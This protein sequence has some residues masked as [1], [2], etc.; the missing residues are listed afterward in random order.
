MNHLL[1]SSYVFYLCAFWVGN[2]TLGLPIAR[3]EGTDS[4][5][6]RWLLVSSRTVRQRAIPRRL[7]RNL[8]QAL[9]QRGIYVLA[10]HEAKSIFAKKHSRQARQA[11]EA[12]LAYIEK[13]TQAALEH[14]A[15][16]HADR[17]RQ[18]AMK[19]MRR[20]K[21]ALESLNRQT[22][23]A[24]QVQN[25][26]LYLARAMLDQ[27]NRDAALKH[28][29]QC[30]SLVPDL[31][32]SLKDH[33]PHVMRLVDEA[34]LALATQAHGALKVSSTPSGCSV[35]INGRR[36]GASPYIATQ[37][38]QGHYRLQVACGGKHPSRVHPVHLGSKNQQVHIDARF[39][40]RLRTR[41]GIT[42]RYASS[43][44]ENRYRLCDA[45]RIA[46]TL[47]ATSVVL[48]TVLNKQHLR[49]DHIDVRSA[50][51][52]ASLWVPRRRL[53][54]HKHASTLATHLHTGRSIHWLGE[55]RTRTTP[56]HPPLSNKK[57]ARLHSPRKAP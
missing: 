39:E 23:V 30:R 24:Q 9:R 41:K 11:R 7:E 31:R 52:V 38:P 54:K 57:R 29:A 27:G 20:A 43:A 16:G 51:V 21:Q 6:A 48:I 42:L 37:L 4:T 47:Q 5:H 33:P 2:L 26:C 14:V 49:L 22:V 28:M 44:Q 12:D 10:G 8:A 46:K 36:V 32:P 3:A 35:M 25:S 17:T 19:V 13:H 50:G 18:A 53:R 34:E 15:Q 40:K 55:K 1:S 45:L 56:W